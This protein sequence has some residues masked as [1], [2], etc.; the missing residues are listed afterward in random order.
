MQDYRKL[1]VWKKAHMLVLDV[2]R[3]TQRFPREGYASLKTQMTRA[4]ESIPFNIVEGC[5]ADT[6]REM[7]RFLDIS[8]KSTSE[9]EYQLTLA[10]D[11]EVL[12]QPEWHTLATTT[13]EVRRMLCGLRAK[14]LAAEPRALGRKRKTENGSTVNPKRAAPRRSA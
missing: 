1:R 14:V 5:G 12:G 3:A 4:A 8:I 13:V 9:L 2:R 7:A 10:K 11:Y 6:A